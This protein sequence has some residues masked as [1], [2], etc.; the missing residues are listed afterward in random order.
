VADDADIADAIVGFHAQQTVEKAIKGGQRRAAI[1]L[2]ILAA[3]L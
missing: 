1:Y 3:P 2:G